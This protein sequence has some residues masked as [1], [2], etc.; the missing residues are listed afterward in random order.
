MDA[1]G[2]LSQTSSRRNLVVAKRPTTPV[3]DSEMGPRIV[4]IDDSIES[5]WTGNDEDGGRYIRLGRESGGTHL[6]CTLE[7]IQPGGRPSEYHYHI[8]NEEALYVV[9]GTG[10][11]RTPEAE[12]AIKSGDYVAFPIGESGSHAVK[13]TSDELLRCLFFSTMREPDVTVYPDEKTLYVGAIKKMF[14]FN[15]ESN[16]TDE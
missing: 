6:G 3:K 8:A 5:K 2:R 14:S 1:R 15:V 7:D 9:D 4:N 11:L 13:N 12:L 16:K 10:T